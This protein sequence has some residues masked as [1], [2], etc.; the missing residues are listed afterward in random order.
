M[1]KP[2]FT[3]KDSGKRAK[4]A[5]G[6]VRDTSEGK[7]RYRRCFDGPM[8]K[9]WAEHL[10][11]GAIKYPDV[12][13]GVANWTLAKSEVECQRFRES[14]VSHFIDWYYGKLDEDH[15]AA[16]FFN[17]NGLEYVKERL[18]RPRRKASKRWKK[19]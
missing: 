7:I 11:K 5:S 4:F 8:F 16:L 1:T 13:P 10:S 14:A 18:K 15:A 17:V 19:Q 6:M 3:I 2:K 12:S 9:R